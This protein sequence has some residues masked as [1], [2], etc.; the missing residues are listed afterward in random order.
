M[1][2]KNKGFLLSDALICVLIVSI[3]SVI[4][5]ICIKVH[6]TINE[7][8]QIQCEKMEEDMQEFYEGLE[9]C[10]LCTTEEEEVSLQNTY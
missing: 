3:L 6:T 8:I 4:V 5:T 7:N 1:K 2:K 9:G 10:V